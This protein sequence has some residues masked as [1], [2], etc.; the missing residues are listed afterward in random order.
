MSKQDW[1]ALV[2]QHC[3]KDKRICN[4]RDAYEVL[5]KNIDGDSWMCEA[6]CSAAQIIA[7]DYIAGKILEQ[8]NEQSLPS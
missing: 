3:P 4:C 7:R 5:S 8:A 1:Q 2:K 6:G